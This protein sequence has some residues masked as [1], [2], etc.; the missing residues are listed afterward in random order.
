MA[1]FLNADGS[2][3]DGADL[4]IGTTETELVIPNG[5]T[6]VYAQCTHASQ[7]ATFAPRA[8]TSIALSISSSSPTLIWSGPALG[9]LRSV[10]LKGSNSATT[11]DAVAFS[12]RP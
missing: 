8:G 12:D 2:F 6:L 10:Y 4:S 5:A 1:T 11:V 9:G 7:T 3:P